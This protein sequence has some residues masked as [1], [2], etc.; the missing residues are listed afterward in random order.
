MQKTLR[1]T[2]NR[3]LWDR[4]LRKSDYQIWFVHRPVGLK[5]VSAD[6]VDRV[7]RFALVIRGG[8]VV[9]PLHRVVK[10]VHKPSG[11]EV[12]CKRQ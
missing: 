2:L 1:D 12:W 5:S 8:E 4:S 6:E 7:T 9:I 10:V 3:I 11:E